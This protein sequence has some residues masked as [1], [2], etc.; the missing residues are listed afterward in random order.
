[1]KALL[2]SEVFPPQTGGSGRWLH[3]LYR[4]RP[5]GSVIVVAGEYAGSEAFDREHAL[6]TERLPLA[7]PTWGCF[8]RQGARHYWRAFGRLLEVVRRERPA[9][10]H[11]GKILPEGWLAWLLRLRLGLPYVLFVHGEEMSVAASSRE[12]SWLTRRVLA[13]AQRIVVNS[14][15]TEKILTEKWNVA[16]ERI[17][18]IHPGV[19][20]QRFCPAPRDR[21]TRERLGWGERPVIITVGRLQKRKGHEM[22]IR[23]LPKIRERVQDVLYSI[24][25]DGQERKEIERQVTALGLTEHVQLRGE[26][27]DQELIE[28][29]QQCDLFVLP[30]RTVDGDFEGFGL[31]LVEAQACGKPVIAGDSGG[32]RETMDLGKTGVIINCDGPEQLADSITEQ[33]L[34]RR[35]REQMGTAARDWAV[36]QFDW[37]QLAEQLSAIV[38]RDFGRANN[39]VDALGEARRTVPAAAAGHR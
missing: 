12:L 19:D 33:L 34:D 29:Y 7:F 30:N 10:V 18:V 16:A 38:D 26:P 20:T 39:N 1:M 36:E 13:G 9:A 24:V 15:N 35:R 32:T 23:A 17:A 27:V 14:R 8:S 21:A 25:G 11:C 22:L 37:P 31:V 6:T 4:R 5:A 2:L 3:E 28:C